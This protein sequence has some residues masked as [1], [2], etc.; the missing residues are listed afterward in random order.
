MVAPVDSL[1]ETLVRYRLLIVESARSV[2]LKRTCQVKILNSIREKAS[3]KAKDEK[4]RSTKVRLAISKKITDE[5]IIDSQLS[6]QGYYLSGLPCNPVYCTFCSMVVKTAQILPNEEVWDVFMAFGGMWS[7]NKVRSG[8]DP[9]NSDSV[10]CRDGSHEKTAFEPIF[11]YACVEKLPLMEFPAS[12]LPKVQVR[13]EETS[14]NAVAPGYRPTSPVEAEEP[15]RPES[16]DAVNGGLK[17]HV[18]AD[19]AEVIVENS[20]VN[21][22]DNSTNVVI[23]QPQVHQTDNSTGGQVIVNPLA[24]RSHSEAE[25]GANTLKEKYP[26]CDGAGPSVERPILKGV[27]VSDKRGFDEKSIIDTLLEGLT[28]T[29]EEWY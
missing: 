20:S 17:L 24:K 3:K 12:K 16:P 15:Y 29:D 4:S 22:T 10:C 19:D 8:C 6:V 13:E 26:F 25:V 18:P 23:T 5:M 7:H 14:Y 21:V 27:R 1:P 28:E 11:R 9:F 2:A